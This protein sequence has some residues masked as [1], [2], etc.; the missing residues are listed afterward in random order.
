MP[1]GERLYTPAGCNYTPA[2][3][4]ST[5]NRR[6]N[7]PAGLPPEAPEF[8]RARPGHR[9]GELNLSWDRVPGARSYSVQ[10]SKDNGETWE[11]LGALTKSRM[12]VSGLQ[13]GSKPWFRVSTFGIQGYSDFS[14]TAQGKVA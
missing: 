9:E 7:T 6:I 12:V 13:S 14:E 1:P 8:L 10:L 3:C 2:R 4:S 11:D 5:L